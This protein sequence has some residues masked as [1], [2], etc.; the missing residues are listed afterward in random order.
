MDNIKIN[1]RGDEREFARGISGYEVAQSIGAGLAKAACA[2]AINGETA[3]LRA[4][5][6]Q[7][8]ALSILTFDHIRRDCCHDVCVKC[9]NEYRVF[10]MLLAVLEISKN[11]R[12]LNPC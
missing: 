6:E 7:D 4:P 8:C 12:Q 2:V 9:T 5:I 11:K 10:I 3:D 1:L